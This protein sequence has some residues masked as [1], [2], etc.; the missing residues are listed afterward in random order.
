MALL[1][2]KSGA[3][4]NTSTGKKT[5]SSG[6][7]SYQKPSS[8][9]SGSSNSS[10]NVANNALVFD[11][12][13]YNAQFNQK[14][15]TL[16]SSSKS[17]LEKKISSYSSA[18]PD[19]QA[20]ANAFTDYIKSNP[21]VPVNDI[22]QPA[23]PIAIPQPPKTDNY[24]TTIESNNQALGLNPDGSAKTTATA[25]TSTYEGLLSQFGLTPPPAPES[26]G[27]A[28]LKAQKSFDI[29]RKEQAVNDYSAQLNAITAK[30]QADQLATTGQGRGI[31][32][33]IIGG[34]QA[35]IAK[36]AAIQA[37]PVQAQL[38]AAQGNL[39]TAKENLDTYY[40]I[41]SQDIQNQYSYKMK[42]YDT[43]V[44]IANT[45][46]QNAI[47]DKRQQAQFKQQRDME[48]LNY[49]HQVNL[50]SI[51]LGQPEAPKVVS[52]NGVDSIYNFSTGKFEPASTSGGGTNQVVVEPL[53][54]KLNLL[55]TAIQQVTGSGAV[56]T[57]PLARTSLTSWV[58]GA[59]QEF[60][61]NIKQLTSQETLDSLLNLKKAGGTLGALSDQERIMLQQAATKIGGW[62]MRDKNGIGTGF[63]DVKEST[64]KAE[65]QRL[66]DLTKKAIINADPTYGL[67]EVD[68]SEIQNIAGGSNSTPNFNPSKFY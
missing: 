28:Y 10:K 62:E 33:S 30:S 34:Q 52:V 15:P 41:V 57:N 53:K 2:S 3:S 68:M 49:Q 32:E 59:R 56:G 29:K 4:Y 58:T 14:T 26:A 50:K 31:T 67:D 42:L 23:T 36:E 44:S 11:T 35:Q 37:L 39:A 61:G 43:A 65:L 40:K 54:Q 20:L 16:S 25:P 63:Y 45:Q 48:N 19:T 60:Q 51:G 9:S 47:E 6:S 27:D 18:N 1:K 55:D 13:A 5:S 38:A 8:S 22:M 46:Q 64:F 66:Q 21:A 7:V 12:P 17:A 24:Q